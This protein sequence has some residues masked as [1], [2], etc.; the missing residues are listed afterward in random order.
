MYES[1]AA[2]VFAADTL[3]SKPINLLFQPADSIDPQFSVRGRR[4]CRPAGTG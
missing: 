3:S 4:Y 1:A 2:G